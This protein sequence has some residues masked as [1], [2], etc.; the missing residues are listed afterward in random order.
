VRFRYVFLAALLILIGAALLNMPLSRR[1]FEGSRSDHVIVIVDAGH[2]GEDGGAVGADGT[3]ESDLN[4]SVA[5]R[6]DLLLGLCGIPSKLTRDSDDIAYPDSAVTTRQRK[7][8]DQEYRAALIG[9][10]DKAVLVSIHQNTY[11]SPGPSGAQVFFGSA[12]GSEGFAK[13]MQEMLN[14][15]CRGKRHAA[16]VS[17]D[18]YLFRQAS[19]PSILVE[20][21]FLSNPDEL[22]LLRTDGYR[23]KLALVL[24]AGCLRQYHEL[25][26]LYGKG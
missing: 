25:E 2:G 24:A 19:C 4:L 3:K 26:A 16:S 10:T 14:G 9:S 11:P 15:L 6:L 17:E 23:A 13:T 12:P 20:C 21:G 18:I 8:A 5:L 1:V 7:R 22:A